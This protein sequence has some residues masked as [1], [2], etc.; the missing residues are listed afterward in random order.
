MAIKDKLYE[1]GKE[2]RDTGASGDPK[3]EFLRWINMPGSG[4]RNS[5][6]IRPFKYTGASWTNDPSTHAFIILITS[7]GGHSSHNPWEDQI[8]L[9]RGIVKY[10][11]DAKFHQRKGID[12][13]VGNRALRQAFD[14]VQNQNF[15]QV[16]PILHFQKERTGFVRFTGIC[17]LQDLSISWFEDQGVPVQNYHATLRIID[18]PEISTSWLID[19]RYAGSKEEALENAPS[20]W[21]RYATDRTVRYLRTWLPK[22]RR[23]SDRRPE[24]GSREETIIEQLMTLDPFGFERVVVALLFRASTGLIHEIERTQN[25]KDTGFDFFGTFILPEPFYYEIR[26]RGEVKRHRNAIGPKDVSRLVARLERAEYGI[27]VTT[28]VFSKQT[29]EEVYERD[30]PIHLIDGLQ[31]VDIFVKAGLV[32]GKQ[33][34]KDWLDMVLS[35]DDVR[36]PRV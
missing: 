1:V 36:S 29:Q 21:R 32:S 4:M 22:I 20:Q 24:P 8:D 17:T 15:K 33:I 9:R 11:G 12:D 28:S 19:R 25:V 5:P 16:P 14:L 30:Y 10:W 31:L 13:F 35:I 34:N 3:D 18:E 27:F 23:P 7:H 6:G 2:Y 26:F